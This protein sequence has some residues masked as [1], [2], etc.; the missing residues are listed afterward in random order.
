MSI[1]HRKDNQVQ[2]NKILQRMLESQSEWLE[3]IIKHN[4]Y[5]SVYWEST[6]Y[7]DSFYDFTF[8]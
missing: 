2:G 4:I 7:W 3:V 8:I 5:D 1:I 6:L